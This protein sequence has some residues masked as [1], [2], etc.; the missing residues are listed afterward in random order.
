MINSNEAHANAQFIYK[1]HLFIKVIKMKEVS[2]AW[3]LPIHVQNV[4]IR[5]GDFLSKIYGFA[6]MHPL[7]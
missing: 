5:P 2:M 1:K 3:P 4:K 6:D 7:K